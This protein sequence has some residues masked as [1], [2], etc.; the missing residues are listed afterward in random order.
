[1]T[2]PKWLKNLRSKFETAGLT[3]VEQSAP[4]ASP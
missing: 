2:S 3:K 1:M 4:K